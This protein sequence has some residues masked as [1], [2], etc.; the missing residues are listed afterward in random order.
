MIDTA[1][2]ADLEEAQIVA[3][4]DEMRRG[5]NFEA[6]EDITGNLKAQLETLGMSAPD[7]EFSATTTTTAAPLTL[8]NRATGVPSK[9]TT[10]SVKAL[11]LRRFPSD[12]PTHA[13]QLVWTTVPMEQRVTAHLLCP[14]HPKSEKRALLDSLGAG[15]IVCS[16]PGGLK[17]PIDVE[18]HFR[19]KHRAAYDLLKSHEEEA[20]RRESLEMQRLQTEALQRL[21]GIPPSERSGQLPEIA[22][23]ALPQTAILAEY[24]CPV[25]GCDWQPA[26]TVKRPAFALASHLRVKHPEEQGLETE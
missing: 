8:W 15:D 23:S 13:G 24:T 14:C 7:G 17:T 16:R 2:L 26:A 11:L 19:I 6:R 12:H 4:V 5:G 25:G 9:A 3:Q 21:A 22:R 1:M 10:D 20:H 18:R